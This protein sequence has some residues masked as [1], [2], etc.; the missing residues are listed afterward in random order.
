M[1]QF[2]KINHVQAAIIICAL[3]NYMA[4]GE[5]V[6]QALDVSDDNLDVEILTGTVAAVEN[7][8][9]LKEKI[10]ELFYA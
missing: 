8:K 7:S 5:A 6:L 3:D 4:E 9:D 1:T 2:L 10:L